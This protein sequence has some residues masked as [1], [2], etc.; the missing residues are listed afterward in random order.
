MTAFTSDNVSGIHP[1]IFAAL[2]DENSGY[3]MPYGNDET[4][5][6]LDAA[7]SDL[8]EREVA[9]IPC[10]SGTAANAIGLSLLAG[11]INSVLVHERSHVY[12]DECNAP[13]FYSN[14]RLEPLKGANCKIDPSEIDRLL[15][16]LGEAHSPQP[17]AISITQS[18]EVGL[19]HTLEELSE[20]VDHSKKGGLRVHMDGARFANAV[21]SLNCSPAEMTWK[22]GVDVLSFGATKNGCMAAEAIVLFDQNLVKQAKYRQKRAGQLLSKNRFLAAQLL[23]YLNDQLWLENARQGNN[24]MKTFVEQLSGLNGVILPES[25]DSNMMFCGFSQEQNRALQEAGLAGYLFEDGRMRLVCSWATQDS[26][27][28]GFINCVKAA[29]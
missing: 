8:F 24:Q 1:A 2:S 25:V 5:A 9:V 11:P 26:D 13:E 29:I 14:A 21:A 12:V 28:D 4:S 22:L 27:I 18:N 3:R 15:T 6:R 16:T 10:T 20:L 17:S 23:A 7:F 19:V